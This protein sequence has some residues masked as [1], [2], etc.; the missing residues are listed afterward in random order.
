MDHF[1]DITLH[2]SLLH[3]AE[4]QPEDPLHLDAQAPQGGFEDG[5]CKF[6]YS[7]RILALI[8]Q[9]YLIT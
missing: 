2:R 8:N 9:L 6:R 7:M 1:G 5:G 4:E 3:V